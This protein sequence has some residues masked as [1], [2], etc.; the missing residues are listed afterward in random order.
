MTAYAYPSV[1]ISYRDQ[2]SF[3]QSIKEEGF[4]ESAKKSEMYASKKGCFG[5]FEGTWL[6]VRGGPYRDLFNQFHASNL[7]FQV[8]N[9]E[10]VFVRGTFTI[11]SKK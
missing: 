4:E 5:G 8:V 9:R 10:F 7:G 6:V 1:N 2:K 11:E 3:T